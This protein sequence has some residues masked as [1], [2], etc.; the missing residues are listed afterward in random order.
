MQWIC[1]GIGELWPKA[2]PFKEATLSA[3]AAVY[4]A[5][6]GFAIGADGRARLTDQA[7]A[8]EAQKRM[9]SEQE[10]KT[11]EA[12]TGKANIAYAITGTGY[13]ADKSFSV[14]AE[15]QKAATDL[16]ATEF[17]NH[18]EYVER[19]CQIVSGRIAEAHKEGHF[20]FLHEV[21]QQA[22]RRP[23]EIEVSAVNID[24]GQAVFHGRDDNL[25]F[26]SSL[27]HMTRSGIAVLHENP[28]IHVSL[29]DFFD[30]S[31]F[32]IFATRPD[33]VTI[34][35]QVD[36]SAFSLN[37]LCNHIFENFRE[38]AIAKPQPKTWQLADVLTYSVRN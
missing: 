27:D 6:Y 1:S 31:S 14:V 15:S 7:A 9:E 30:G 13:D 28:Y 12:S 18:L 25:T 26:L 29:I 3:I 19:F 24:F 16:A 8:T 22:A 37:R 34:I 4:T 20:D 23:G 35:P 32:D 11:F 10:Q 33:S 5:K 36:A 17:T 21:F 2:S 38:G